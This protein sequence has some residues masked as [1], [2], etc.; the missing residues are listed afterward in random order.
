MSTSSNTSNTGRNRFRSDAASFS[1]SVPSP[2]MMNQQMQ[3]QQQHIYPQYMYGSP[4]MI[5]NQYY[6]YMSPYMMHPS[7]AYS[8]F[9]PYSQAYQAYPMQIPQYPGQPYPAMP[10]NLNGGGNMNMNMVNNRPKPNHVN[11]SKSYIDSDRSRSPSVQSNAQASN[12]E[13]H[14]NNSKHETEQPQDVKPKSEQPKPASEPKPE[15]KDDTKEN[16]QDLTEVPVKTQDIKA[17]PSANKPL[18]Y[19]LYFNQNSEDFVSSQKS[20]VL[21]RKQK[22]SQKNERLKEFAKVHGNEN[23]TLLLNR[24]AVTIID[25]NANT[26]YQT[27]ENNNYSNNAISSKDNDNDDN[28]NN[29]N[30]NNESGLDA[31]DSTGR[32]KGLKSSNWAAF[33]QTTAAVPSKKSKAAT[34][35]TSGSSSS[36]NNSISGAST[37]TTTAP[38]PSSNILSTDTSQPL[39]ILM[40]KIMFDHNYSIMNSYSQCPVFMVKPRGLT[41]TG[42]ICYMNAILQVLLYCEPFNKTLKL[43]E[44][45]SIGSLSQKS[46]TPLL[47]IVI[48]FFNE[49]SQPSN[50][51]PISPDSFYMN[52]ITHEKFSHLKWGQQED[53]EEFLGYFLDGLHEEFLGSIKNLNIPQIDLLIQHYQQQNENL[54]A[55]KINEFKTNIKNTM[56]IVKKTKT[57]SNQEKAQNELE[58]SDH[59]NDGWSEVGTNNKKVSAKRTVEIEPSPITTTFG[60]QFRSVLQIP[61]NKESQSITLDPFQCI[62]LDISDSS[63]N[64]VEDAFKNLN[65]PEKIPYKSSSNKEVIAKKQTYIDHLPNILIIHLKRFSYQQKEQNKDKSTSN[66]SSPAPLS[67]GS[68]S[69]GGIEKLRKKIEYSHN[70]TIPS[71]VL[72]PLTKQS[73]RS[74]DNHYKLFGVVYHH[75][76]SAEGGHYTSDVLRKSSIFDSEEESKEKKVDNQWIRIDDTQITNLEKEEVL[77]GGDEDTTKNAYI[78]FY[79]KV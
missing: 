57:D 48:K 5:P 1:P 54:D 30:D 60:G 28:F 18:S 42:N 56:K 73:N 19:P 17:S 31:E 4:Q 37:A 59:E 74:T 32:F 46:S 58:A 45:K 78:L 41:N 43:I 71:E 70:L 7:T 26:T 12:S 69:L 22:A 13:Q 44:S 66:T 34:K 61:R 52:L 40:L 6:P 14:Q 55:Q 29:F 64:T 63:I 8:E 23:K 27:L 11:K 65:E 21:E 10:N 51:K 33:L 75:G 2:G 3:Q 49:F 62:Q 36:I 35:P 68:R 24:S 67:N 39:G 77:N 79:Q 20:M 15:P 25:Y 50:S 76:S 9:N 16:K 53:A 38:Q 47:D 72:S